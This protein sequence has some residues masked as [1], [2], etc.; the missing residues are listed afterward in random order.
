MAFKLE[1]DKAG[2]RLYHAG[3]KNVVLYKQDVSGNYVNGEAWNGVTSIN[4]NPSGAEETKL[5]ADDI[6]YLGMRS[7]EEYGATLGCYTYPD[8]WKEC[9]GRHVPV[10]GLSIGQQ[11][12]SPFGLSYITTVGNDTEGENFGFII[13]L[14]YGLT[15]SPS[16]QSHETINDSPEAG[17]FSYEISSTPVNV[18]GQ[19]PTSTIEI[20]SWKFS[21]EKIQSFLEILYGT[22]GQTP[23]DATMPLPDD[24]IAYFS[25]N[26]GS[27]SGEG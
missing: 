12:R 15:A 6:K 19:K 11:K 4:E 23:V 7:A 16:E 26:S 13:H 27:G 2:E 10:E 20:E 24:V 25:N 9:D 3:V 5:F 17:E 22:A 14:A 18:T 8:G 1:W 21:D